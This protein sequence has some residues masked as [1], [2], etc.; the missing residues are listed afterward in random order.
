[1]ARGGLGDQ[2]AVDEWG[3]GEGGEVLSCSAARSRL[4]RPVVEGEESTLMCGRG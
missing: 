3:E 1:M 2:G 4:S